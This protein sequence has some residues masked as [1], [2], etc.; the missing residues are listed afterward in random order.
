MSNSNDFKCKI[1][2]NVK[3]KISNNFKSLTDNRRTALSHDFSW[4]LFFFMERKKYSK[5]VN[6]ASFAALTEE[7]IDIVCQ[8]DFNIV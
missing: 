4:T 3:C 5:S 2:S 1:I 6:I 8:H 7:D